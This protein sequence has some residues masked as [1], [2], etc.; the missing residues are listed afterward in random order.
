VRPIPQ[1]AVDFVAKHEGFRSAAYQDVAGVWTIGF[2]T[3]KG[4]K[5][6]DKITRPQALKRLARDMVEA[7][8]R[9]YNVV[10]P[11]VIENCLTEQQWAAL[12][13]FVYNLGAKASWTIWKRLN[14]RQFDQVPGEMMK[15]VNAGGR[16]IQGLVNRRAEEVKLWS[17][18][19]PGSVEDDPPSSI[20]RL[21]ET[22]PTPSSPTP[23]QK[24]P[25]II[26]GAVSAIAAVPA[27][28]T[29]VM[30]V[31]APY[32]DKSELVEKMIATLATIGAI[33]AVLVVIFAWLKKQR[34]RQ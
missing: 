7:Q 1:I 3:I 27:A 2:G 10:K 22:P 14:S 18:D 30:G 4:V 21:M 32:A 19:E 23:P 16:K 11:E 9:L 26:A 31:V 5:A 33:A 12:L 29:H 8:E 20:T 25:T 6:G 34:E 28:T 24:S 15:F 17:T 13:S